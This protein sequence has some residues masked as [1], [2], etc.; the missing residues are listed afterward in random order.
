VSEQTADELT[1]RA[2][3]SVNTGEGLSGD[4]EQFRA[5]MDA[6]PNL[7]IV[8]QEGRIVFFNQEALRASG[9]AAHEMRNMPMITDVDE[10]DRP[11]VLENSRRRLTGEKIDDYEIIV[12]TQ[13]GEPRNA[14][15]RSTLI[16]YKGRPATL[17][18]LID[19]TARKRAEEER[20]RLILD[21]K[22]AISR[23]RTLSGMLPICS[24]CKKIRD[25]K[26]YW[27][28]I[29]VYVR[30]HTEADFSHGICPECA[31]KLYPEYYKD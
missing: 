24:S 17:A 8:H 14:I 21:L 15:V 18:M 27:E 13:S 9:R 6:L 7:V 10:A 30:N 25:D 31:E 16:T 20:E 2:S 28:Q 29:E 23:I 1:N 12:R 26:G 3:F 19:N 4:E 22:D 11:S 5:L